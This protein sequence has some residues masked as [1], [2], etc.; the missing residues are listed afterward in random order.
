[1][2]TNYARLFR[3]AVDD[4]QRD[5]YHQHRELMVEGWWQ[6]RLR[7]RAVWVPARTFWTDAE[8]GMPDN[9]LD[10]WPLPFLTAEIAG[11]MADP[12]DVFGAPERREIMP[13]DG[14][15]IEQEYAYL[16]ATLRHAKTHLPD[17]PLANP[18]RA[19]DLRKME[20]LF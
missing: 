9:I 2:T 3:E 11:E 7:K 16:V 17:N 14:L 20:S 5:F 6:V 19:I 1:M 15:S 12:L 4:G 18:K 8:P 10:R 13:N